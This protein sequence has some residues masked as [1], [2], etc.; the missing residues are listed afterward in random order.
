LELYSEKPLSR[1]PFGIGHMYIIRICSILGI[2]YSYETWEYD[3]MERGPFWEPNIPSADNKIPRFYETKD[4]VPCLNE[5]PTGS[6]H[7]PVTTLPS[8]Y[9]RYILICS[10]HLCLGLPGGLFPSRFPTKMCAFITYPMCAA[11]SAHLFLLDLIR[12]IHRMRHRGDG[13]WTW[14]NGILVTY[15]V[16]SSG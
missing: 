7:E 10:S 12:N 15:A 6:Y 5:L 14:P 16:T 8:Y 2:F 9:L 11:C 3:C 1:K 4:S 13:A